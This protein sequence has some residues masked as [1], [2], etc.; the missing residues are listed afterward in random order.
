MAGVRVVA[1][2]RPRLFGENV[3]ARDMAGVRVV[4][5]ARPRLFGE[6]VV[7]RTEGQYVTY[8]STALGGM[9]SY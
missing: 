9:S 7:A 5:A 2:A 8:I 3:V 1:A 6:N 4:A